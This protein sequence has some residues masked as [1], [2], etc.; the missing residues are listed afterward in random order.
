MP[1]SL[2]PLLLLA[3]SACVTQ[4]Q[5]ESALK[6]IGD[7]RSR[8]EKAEE[9]RKAAEARL[10]ELEAQLQSELD[11]TKEE[12]DELRR[13]RE[14]IDRQF[15]ELTAKLKSL[16]DAG[17]LEVYMRRGLIMIGMSSQVLFPSGK[18]D[19]S[20]RGQKALARIATVMAELPERRMQVA[21]HTDDE[22]IGDKLKLEWQDNWEL[23][24][25]R[26]LTVTRFLVSKGVKPESIS[27]A[28]YGEFDPVA[29]NK[30]T[31]GRRKNRRIELILVP[32]LSS[33]GKAAGAGQ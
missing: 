24:T 4:G 11:A 27:A 30:G 26:S 2:L 29:D 9:E 12:L 22:P 19:L 18:A 16:I 5:Y 25:A 33:I 20:D 32:D 7:A 14:E 1:R 15:N 6:D 21:G 28:G 23:S 13:Q 8:C 10:A 3:G 17:D 31:A